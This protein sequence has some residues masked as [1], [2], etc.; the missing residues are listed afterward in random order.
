MVFRADPGKIV[1]PTVKGRRTTPVVF[2]HDLFGELRAVTGDVGGRDVLNRNQD[3]VV[4]LEMGEAY[5]D[6]D[7]DT[8][9]DLARMMGRNEVAVPKVNVAHKSWHDPE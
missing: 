1:M 7:L 5:D 4:S 9:E 6:V 3:R 2:P 8:P